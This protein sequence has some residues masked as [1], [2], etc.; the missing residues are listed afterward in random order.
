MQLVV[1]ELTAVPVID[2]VFTQA[3]ELGQDASQQIVK[4]LKIKHM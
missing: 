1:E 3:A 2:N 4:I